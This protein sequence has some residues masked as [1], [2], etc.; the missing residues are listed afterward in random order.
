ME[1]Q[2]L[3][4]NGELLN[5]VGLAILLG[6]ITKS[7][8]IG[9]H[10]W[11]TRSMEG[12]TPVSALL[13]AA[14]M[15][16]AGVYLMLRMNLILEW[17]SNLLL[18]ITWFGG[19]SAL[20]GAI[21]GLLEQDIKKIIAY[22]TIS[23]LGYMFIAIGFSEYNLS[24]WHLV[25]H[26]CFK[27][28]LFLSGGAL[29]HSLYGIQDIR[30][31]GRLSSTLP[32]LRIA[33]LIGNL[34]IMAIPF[35]TGW[36]TKD[37]ILL[38]V[39]K[40]NSFLFLLI[41]IAAIF[42]A[43]YSIKLFLACFKSLP[44]LSANVYSFIIPG[45]ASTMTFGIIVLMICAV[46]FGYF[47]SAI[48]FF[49]PDTISQ[50][51]LLSSNLFLFFM[52]LLMFLSF[53]MLARI[54]FTTSLTSFRFFNILDQIDLIALSILSRFIAPCSTYLFRN[55]QGFIEIFMGG[56][57]ITRLIEAIAF[58][59]EL[60]TGYGSFYHLAFLVFAFLCFSAF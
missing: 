13:H 4:L 28:L 23:Q 45:I 26:A 51:S 36:W 3:T 60:L 6:A 55:Y 27:A 14:T 39:Y 37:Q 49:T 38:E 47:S 43:A 19:L 2:N 24:L 30:K 21:G 17:S 12:P 15:V 59:L 40:Y 41:Y 54:S 58:R 57:G 44:R 53:F 7:A 25:N 46:I 29:I 22:S 18:I 20:G 32:L 42:T 48:N 16:T 31:F 5:L 1:I 9:L 52:I 35:M 50:F 8:Q 33:F 10:S 34:S 56:T 11:L